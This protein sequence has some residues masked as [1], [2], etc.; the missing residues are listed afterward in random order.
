M[1]TTFAR[2]HP[3]LQQAIVARLGWTSL[4]PV[5]ELAG[6]VIL[7]GQHAI[8]LAPTAGGKTEAALFPVISSLLERQPAG[9]GALYVA[10]IK[11]LLNNQ[12]ERL[13]TYTEMVGLRRTV[14]H[15]DT[16]QRVKR[17]FLREPTDLL[18]TTPESLEVMLVSPR[19]PVARL[20]EDL[21]FVVVDEI[22][23]LAGTDR[24]AH[25]MSVLERLCRYS[26]YDPQRVGLSATVGNPKE[27]LDWLR[28]SSQRTG[29]VVD[30]P[31]VAGRRELLV[32]CRSSLDDLAIDASRLARG[33][34]SL[35]FCQSRAVTE[36]AAERMRRTGIE[37]FVHHSSVSA[38][39]RHEAEERFHHGSDACIVCTSTLEL[40]IDV[41]DLDRVLQANA[42][43]TVSSFLQRM[44]RT[45]RRT[46][47][48][49]NTTFLCE[50]PYA[51]LQAVAL[52]E[53]ARSGWVEDVRVPNRC[54]P[55]LVH[56]TFVM[57]V[58]AGAMAA[59]TC[60]ERL[61]KVPDFSGV[62]AD[63]YEALIEHLVA[64]DY[65]Y[66]ADGLLSLGEVAERVFG[67]KNFMELYAVFSSPVLFRV[68]TATGHELGSLEQAFV[69][70]LVDE[71]AAFLL[72]GRAWSVDQ[73]R[74]KD[75][76]VKVSEA[77]RGKRPS[78][79]GFVPQLH[80]RELC[81]RMR[82]I[83][84][85]DQP[86]PYLHNS[87]VEALDGLREA[88]G[89][90]AA[91]DDP[92]LEAESGRAAWWTFAGGRI[93]HTLRYGLEVLRGWEIVAD[94]LMLRIEGDTVS[95]TA[96]LGAIT[97]M[98]APG[99][100]DRA[101]VWEAV[102]EKLPAYRLSKFQR[103]LP[104]KLARELVGAWLLDVPGTTALL[105]GGSG[106]TT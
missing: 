99:F 9:V 75:R 4:R 39:E 15:G 50:E 43:S 14:W 61:S 77:P 98:S 59:A 29:S 7:G 51:V 56:Q 57:V 67:R 87:A 8:V 41:G 93:N 53:L 46:G 85:G 90:L 49:S 10:P 79:G 12:A 92:A 23:A 86:F 74:H 33:G 52:V 58:A 91:S 76:V 88:L 34:K 69:D 106:M 1:S 47:Q 38:G 65:L 68:V 95:E 55:V 11:A 60:W 44:G 82:R 37:V 89:E 94:N 97:E 5:Q 35:F 17:A 71:N 45:G 6:D 64:T 81:Q 84:G 31:H 63:E 22:H 100:W 70:R 48:A 3:R 73:I 104:E 102:L 26:R 32:I 105:G 80:G 19:V 2:L 96:V 54:W 101:D 16:P 21:Q 27:I 103:A 28:G 72:G 18:M 83:L 78:W 24:G 25:L 30:P 20:F 62:T 42:P 40:G 13:G 66:R 36:A